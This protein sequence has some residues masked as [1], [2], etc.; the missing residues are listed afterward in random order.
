MQ[1]EL[2]AL[3]GMHAWQPAKHVRK[4]LLAKASP[5][6]ELFPASFVE[7]ANKIIKL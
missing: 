4:Y 1:H 5:H 6:A 3:V 2:P 7:M